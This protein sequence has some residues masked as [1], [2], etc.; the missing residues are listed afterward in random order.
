MPKKPKD[1]SK[2][3]LY[4]LVCNDLNI[5]ECY[6]GHTTHFVK[7]RAEHKSNCNNQNRRHYNYKVYKLIRENGGFDNWT[8]VQIEEYP[9][10]NGN[11]A[12]ARERYWYEK[13]NSTMNTHVPNRSQAEYRTQYYQDN[14]EDRLL[15]RHE[16]YKENEAELKQKFKC[17][18][19]GKYT[20]ASRTIHCKTKLHQKFLLNKETNIENIV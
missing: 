7:R 8:M 2:T 5:T 6:V 13:L 1:F 16:Y 18:C 19:G 11:E 3:L 10:N 15:K 20:K 9:C 17:E 14:R 4:K 12:G